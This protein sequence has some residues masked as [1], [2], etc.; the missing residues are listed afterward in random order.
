MPNSE[1]MSVRCLKKWPEQYYN[2][3][4]PKRFTDV[5]KSPVC[6]I[7][8]YQ[9]SAGEE[10]TKAVMVIILSDVIDFFNVSNSMN[11]NQVM[12]TIEII[13]DN[14]GYL[15]ID[16]FKLCFNQAKRGCFGQ[17]Y[18]MDGNVILSWIETYINDRMNT[19]EEINYAQHASMKMNE[20]RFPTFQELINKKMI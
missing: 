14:Y 4:K 18:R 2:S 8:T 15:K 5:F 12:N 9:R 1:E 3:L 6:T 7:G 20:K 19:A 10:N 11:A 13:L 16:D 17:I